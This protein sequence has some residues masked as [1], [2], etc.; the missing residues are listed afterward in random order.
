MTHVRSVND[1]LISFEPLLA[2][3]GR[4]GDPT[5]WTEKA[6]LFD[7]HGHQLWIA[8]H[9]CMVYGGRYY[10]KTFAI[11]AARVWAEQ[12]PRKS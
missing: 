8:K 6:G 7:Y 3:W 2:G 9:N 5:R 10:A 1:I 11:A 12:N 4:L